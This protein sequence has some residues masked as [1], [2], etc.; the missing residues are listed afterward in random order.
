MAVAQGTAGA[1]MGNTA[2]TVDASLRAVFKKSGIRAA[3]WC[4][5]KDGTVISQAGVGFADSAKALRVNAE[6]TVV[7]AASNGKVFVALS[8]LLVDAEGRLD[9]R[10]DVHSILKRVRLPRNFDA[11]SRSI[12]SSR[13]QAVSGTASSAGWQRRPI[14]SYLWKSFSRYACLRACFRQDAGSHVRI[15]AWRSRDWWWRTRRARG[16]TTWRTR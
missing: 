4:L 12:I 16:S 3:A 15:T 13:I 8:A 2:E 9:L 10:A 14:W 1:P 11:P 5:V 7:R 6:S